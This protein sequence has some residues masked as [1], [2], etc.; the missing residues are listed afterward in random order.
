M[1]IIK[2]KDLNKDKKYFY[3]IFAED[4][5]HYK[6][7]YQNGLNVDN[8][9]DNIK[10]HGNGIYFCELMEIPYWLIYKQNSKY[11]LKVEIPDEAQICVNYNVYGDINEMKT[12][13]IIININEKCLIEDF[14]YFNDEKYLKNA[15]IINKNIFKYIKNQTEEICKIA[16]EKDGL[17]L[18]FVKI[19]TEEIIKKAVKQ[20][21]FS[22]VFALLKYKTIEMCKMIVNINSDALL[23]VNDQTSEI[24]EIAINKNLNALKYVKNKTK[25][26]CELAIN[27]VKS[28]KNLNIIKKE[29]I[30]KI[31]ISSYPFLL[32][33]IDEKT[34][35]ICK[36][37]IY[38]HFRLKLY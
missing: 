21:G 32:K 28:S 31:A 1:K 12:N 15:L 37:A 24:I 27:K 3:K 14:K 38:S 35:E 23:Y 9:F 6:Y 8:N 16:V 2:G 30:Y 10:K 4:F 29:E 26:L 17:L 25:E 20:N 5:T 36:I 22:F 33:L 11:I 7:K 18:Q 13:K 19:Q 34:E